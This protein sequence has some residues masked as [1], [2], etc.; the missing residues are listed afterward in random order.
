M[1]KRIIFSLA[2][3]AMSLSSLLAFQPPTS[4]QGEFVPI[5][6]LP[7]TEQMPAAPFVIGAYALLWLIAMFYVW[8]I[9]NRMNKLETDFQSLQRRHKDAAR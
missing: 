2:M 3:A 9:W 6:Q 1:L 7:P 4:P 5:D 8:T